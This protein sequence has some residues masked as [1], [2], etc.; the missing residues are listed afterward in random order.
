[1]PHR[2]HSIP[3]LSVIFI[4][5]VDAINTES[6]NSAT[7]LSDIL[8]NST[9]HGGDTEVSKES[10]HNNLYF[11]INYQNQTKIPPG[12]VQFTKIGPSVITKIQGFPKKMVQKETKTS[13]D[14]PLTQSDTTS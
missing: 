9:L 14:I 12:G 4:H 1:M 7:S 13:P 3:S 6:T 11:L 10:K 5:S 8:F 2:P